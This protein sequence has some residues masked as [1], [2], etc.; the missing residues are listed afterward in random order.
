M[1]VTEKEDNRMIL[2]TILA[3]TLIFLIIFAVFAI[4]IGGAA[5]I[6]LFG[7]IIVCAVFIIMV[8]KFLVNKRKK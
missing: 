6:V 7:D 2:F 3:L 1:G 8:L 5:V 4:S